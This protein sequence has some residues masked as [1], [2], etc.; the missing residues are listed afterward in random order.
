M[1]VETE[2]G[3]QNWLYRDR[4]T[5]QT[6]LESRRCSALPSSVNGQKENLEWRNQR[7][8]DTG[9]VFFGTSWQLDFPHFLWF[10]SQYRNLEYRAMVKR[11]PL[12]SRTLALR[13]RN[14]LN[15]P[16]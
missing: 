15:E 11:G 5:L 13:W 7:F 8:Y 3:S 9:L 1:S 12:L 10:S 6:G 14:G 16:P 4:F 2:L